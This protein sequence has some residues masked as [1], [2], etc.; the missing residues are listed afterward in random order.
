MLKALVRSKEQVSS[1]LA[2]GGPMI[3]VA[4]FAILL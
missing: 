2:G 4:T 1:C 3:Q